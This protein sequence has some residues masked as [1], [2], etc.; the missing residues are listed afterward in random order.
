M[1]YK[2]FNFLIDKIDAEITRQHT[3]FVVSFSDVDT[4]NLSEKELK[5]RKI[6]S[7]I[8]YKEYLKEECEL[9]SLKDVLRECVLEYVKKKHPKNKE[10]IE[11][12][13]IK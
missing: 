7:D 4:R 8:K 13:K 10:L 6:W 3:R 11:F 5:A 9:R 2:H 1:D 12:W